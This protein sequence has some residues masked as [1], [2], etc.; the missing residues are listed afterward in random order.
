[1]RKVLLMLLASLALVLGACGDDV[2]EKEVGSV[3]SSEKGAETEEVEEVE[4]DVEEINM[5]IVDS[6]IAEVTLVDMKK[7]DK[8]DESRYE[9]AV[10][11]ENKS[12]KDIY[13]GAFDM[14]ADGKMV[15]EEMVD[16]GPSVSAGKKADEKIILTDLFAEDDKELPE[17]DDEIEFTMHVIDGDSYE[18]IEE[19]KVKIDLD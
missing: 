19:H 13:L 15:P 18:T 16:F 12:D 4:D 9:L 8:E 11:I 2:E 6:D 17:I 7:V 1:M 14:S 3:D 5:K 10:E